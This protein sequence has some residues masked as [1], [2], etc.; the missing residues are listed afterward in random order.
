MPEMARFGNKLNSYSI[1]QLMELLEDD[2]KLNKIVQDLEEVR[3][4]DF[5]VEHFHLRCDFI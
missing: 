3:V 1:A 5:T 2:G 4:R